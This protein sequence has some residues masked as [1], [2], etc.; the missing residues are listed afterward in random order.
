MFTRTVMGNSRKYSYPA[1]DGFH[2]LTPPCL[3]KFQNALPPMP[4]EFHSC[5]WSW[6]HCQIF[7]CLKW[8][9]NEAK[10]SIQ[11]RIDPIFASFACQTADNW[12]KSY[13]E[14]PLPFRISLFLAH[15]CARMRAMNEY[16]EGPNVDWSCGPWTEICGRKSV[17]GSLWTEIF[18]RKLWTVDGSESILTTPPCFGLT[19]V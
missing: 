19:K 13:C 17:D 2:V 16:R 15:S 14:P 1:M 18:G 8:H 6:V 4:S 9:T 5:Y 3:R 10:G 12:D 11:C 7:L